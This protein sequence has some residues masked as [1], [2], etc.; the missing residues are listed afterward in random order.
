MRIL[1]KLAGLWRR[2]RAAIY[3]STVICTGVKLH[4]LSQPFAM[5]SGFLYIGFSGFLPEKNILVF[6]TA[7]P[8]KSAH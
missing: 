4:P 5:G 2:S 7:F 3:S 1:L 6:I 8:L